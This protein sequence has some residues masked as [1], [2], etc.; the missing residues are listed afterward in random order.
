MFIQRGASGAQ[1]EAPGGAEFFYLTLFRLGIIS[2]K[3][4]TFSQFPNHAFFVIE[5]LILGAFLGAEFDFELQFKFE[6]VPK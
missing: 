4:T 6:L 5:T 3:Q 1:P 2:K